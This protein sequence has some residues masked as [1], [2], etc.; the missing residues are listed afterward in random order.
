MKKLLA[1]VLVIAMAISVMPL[2]VFADGGELK[3]MS[4]YDGNNK[5]L[6]DAVLK[7][8]GEFMSENGNGFAWLNE[9]EFTITEELQVLSISGWAAFDQEI[10]AYG[11]RLDGGEV[12]FIDEAFHVADDAVQAAAESMGC[13]YAARYHINVDV[14]GLKGKHVIDY[15]TKVADGGVYILNVSGI[16]VTVTYAGVEDPDATPTPEPTAGSETEEITCLPGIFFTFDEEDKYE[17]F[18]IAGKEVEDIG[19]DP[20]KKCELLVVTNSTDPYI[21]LNAPLAAFDVFD[22][23]I[24]CGKYK[25]VSVGVKLDS[26]HGTGG[27]FY[28]TTDENGELGETQVATINYK[29]TTD[30]QAVTA[31]FTKAKK[32]SGMLTILRYDVFGSLEADESTVEVYYVAF[33]ETKADADEFG[34]LFAERGYDIFPE[35][36]TPTPKPTNTPTP[37]PTATP[38]GYVEPGAEETEVPTETAEAGN[39]QKEENKKSGCGSVLGG[40][41]ALVAAAGAVLVIK[42]KKH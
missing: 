3:S 5:C 30:F 26:N 10:K 22:E 29:N 17:D 38:E 4:E 11:Y 36:A 6:I 24:D 39:E 1:L 34:K 23:D 31:N 16:D 15:V 19:W 12:V 21:T 33:F 8:D 25:V 20:E 41:I 42:R 18:F 32:W 28:Y 13:E 2:V 7:N 40:G 27:Q 35:V 9:R 37:T 14:S